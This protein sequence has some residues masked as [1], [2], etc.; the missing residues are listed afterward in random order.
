MSYNS[1]LQ[2]N[3]D[4]LQTILNIVNTLPDAD[5]SGGVFLPELGDTAATS[6]DMVYGKVLYDDEGNP[7]TGNVIEVAEGSLFTAINPSELYFINNKI[8]ITGVAN[9]NSR[10]D[11]ALLR[12]GSNPRLFIE[13]NEFGEAT[14]DDVKKGVFFTSSAGLLAEGNLVEILAGASI[15]ATEDITVTRYDSGAIRIT[16][17]TNWGD[18]SDVV[19]RSGAYLNITAN[20][21]DFEGI[22]E[23]ESSE[24]A[25]LDAFIQGQITTIQNENITEVGKGAFAYTDIENINLPNCITAKDYAFANCSSL[26]DINLPQCKNIGSYAFQQIDIEELALP[27][28][29][30]FGY[31]CFNYSKIKTITLPIGKEVGNYCFSNCS[32]LTNIDAPLL[33]NISSYCFQNCVSLKEVQFDSLKKISGNAFNGS[34]NMFYM[35][36]LPTEKVTLESSTAFLNTPFASGRGYIFVPAEIVDTYKQDNVW[37]T[38]QDRIFAIAPIIIKSSQSG[39]IEQ[40]KSRDYS[41]DL[42]F[43]DSIP[44]VSFSASS[45]CEITNKEVT[46]NGLS[47]T[48]NAINLGEENITI[49]AT[50]GEQQATLTLPIEVIEKLPYEVNNRSTTYGFYL[51]NNDYYESNNKGKNTSYAVCRVT[52]TLSEET[53]VCLD[54]INYAENNWDYGILSNIDTGLS[55]SSTADASAKIYKNFKGL[56][57]SSVQ[58]VTYTIPA[59]EHF[60]DIKYLKDTSNSSNNDSLQFKIRFE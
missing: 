37:K 47:F 21:S 2:S 18:A 40:T 17:K 15:G 13:A 58:T 22:F 50:T 5:D 43:F 38:Y 10:Y 48:L 55:L 31:Q 20:E 23:T 46:Q 41:L 8:R 36:L 44:E 11:G 53:Q 26:K 12:T 54:C 4:D 42:K 35:T 39:V 25:N 52:F 9:I 29:E 59:G 34:A 32:L 30:V 19:V 28:G 7:V 3:N 57:S 60:I 45:I 49:I 16:G 24:D 33:E 51:N 1:D 6:A 14:R 56:S 27:K